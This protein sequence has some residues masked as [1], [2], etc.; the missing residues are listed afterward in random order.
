MVNNQRDVFAASPGTYVL[1][2]RN[3][4]SVFGSAFLGPCWAGES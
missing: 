4:D 2:Q 3:A 1:D